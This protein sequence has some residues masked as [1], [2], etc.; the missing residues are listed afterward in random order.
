M[1]GVSPR[2]KFFARSRPLLS[3]P[4]SLG[5]EKTSIFT[6]LAINESMEITHIKLSIDYLSCRITVLVLCNGFS[7]TV[8]RQI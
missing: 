7:E 2:H 8:M 6:S 3:R 1:N 5:S 4:R